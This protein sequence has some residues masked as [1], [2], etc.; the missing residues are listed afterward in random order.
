MCKTI[1]QYGALNEVSIDTLFAKFCS[2]G[3]AAFLNLIPCLRFLNP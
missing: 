3:S 2:I 1:L